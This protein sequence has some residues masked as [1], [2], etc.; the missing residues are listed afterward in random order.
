MS[1]YR[2]HRKTNYTCIDNQVFWDHSLSLKAKGLL[3]QI[4][5]LPDDWDYSIKGLATLFSDGETAV[6]NAI[7]E[8]IDHGYIVRTQKTNQYGRFDG[9]EYD[10]YET[11][12]T[13]NNITEPE[14][15][16]SENPVTENPLS[17]NPAQLNTNIL[18]TNELNTN[19]IDIIC[20][21]PK[22]SRFIPPTIEEVRAYCRERNSSV[23]PDKF[24]EYFQTGN[25]KDSKGNPV[26]NWKQKII[27]WEKF[28]NNN[29][30]RHEPK[31]DEVLR[32]AM[33]MAGGNTNDES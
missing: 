23:D 10:I 18:S 30:D 31:R 21:K 28:N 20:D 17:E 6:S 25:W 11:P 33:E 22:K 16:Y 29:T 2:R 27:T 7:Q 32:L 12:Q 19:R 8:L 1:V 26:K 24:F 9:Y 4:Y 3:A 13:Q 14:K 5:S 15:P